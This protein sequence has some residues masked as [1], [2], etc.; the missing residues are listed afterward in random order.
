MSEK[1]TPPPTPPRPAATMKSS[2]ST[3]SLEAHE[4]PVENISI[5]G[6]GLAGSAIALL[7][8]NR[9][10]TNITVYEK[11]S[12]S[13]Q[14]AS[15]N[16]GRSINMSLSFRG[17]KTLEKCGILPQILEEGVPM[18]GRMIHHLDGSK[19]F[20]PYSPDPNKFLLSI[21]R[22][23]LNEKL[24]QHV[25][26][27]ESVQFLY[28]QQV[29]EVNPRGCTFTVK[30]TSNNVTRT[31]STSTMIGC[32][33][34]FSA[35]RQS[36]ARFPR[37]EYNQHYME[38]GYKELRI[39]AGPNGEFQ[40]E[41]ECLHIWPRGG[42][43]MI[44][45][46]N[47]DGSFTVTL[48]F[49]FEGD[50]SSFESLNTP[51]RIDRFFR[52]KFP[53]AAP[54][55]PS[56]IEDFETNPVCTLLTIKTYPWAIDGRAVLVGDAAHAIVPFYGQDAISEMAIENFL[57]MRDT[58][59]DDLFVFKKKVE[60]LLEQR[61]PGRYISRY[62]LISFSH[63][64]YKDAQRI[65]KLNQEILN[66]LC[67]DARLNL[68]NIDLTMANNLIKLCGCLVCFTIMGVCN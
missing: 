32:D 4:Q 44:A 6:S 26:G 66:V 23:M 64:P 30:D 3:A 51:E 14:K 54:L 8:K 42:Y 13:E 17:M 59:Q 63:I 20:H 28:N 27:S 40:L 10:F 52:T 60:H 56:L 29:K 1:N 55:I 39:P 33:G 16:R 24:R 61:F 46:P 53:D 57:E 21:S 11:R 45:L 2:S 25:E 36:M 5:F 9:G 35:V 47:K 62:E 43:M 50:G 18:R 12:R 15:W 34:A 41:K 49:P 58:V 37:H 7:L 19:N 22:D 38:H 68:N 48:F 67:K 31:M 65:G